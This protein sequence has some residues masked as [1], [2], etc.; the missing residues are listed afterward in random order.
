MDLSTYVDTLRHELA[1]AARSAGPDAE[2]TGRRLTAPLESATRLVL[3]EAVSDAAQEISR[4]LA[5]GSV[6]VRLR[7]RDLGFVVDR[8]PRDRAAPSPLTRPAGRRPRPPHR[9]RPPTAPRTPAPAPA[10]RRVTP[11]PLGSRPACPSPSRRR[12]RR[13]P[14]AKASRST[15][16]SVRTLG[17]ALQPGTATAAPDWHQSGNQAE[18]VGPVTGPQDAPRDP[19]RDTPQDAR[20]G[21]A[22]AAA[23]D[24][25][26][27]VVAPVSLAVSLEFGTVRVHAQDTGTVTARIWPARA[28]R[29]VDIEAAEQSQVHFADNALEIR[30]PGATRRFFGSPGSVDVDVVVPTGSSLRI[31]AGYAEVE[32]TGTV[33]VCAVKTSYGDIRVDDIGRL[34]V[35]SQGGTVT[36]GRVAGPAKVS[37]TYGRIRIREVAAAADLR[38]RPATSPSLGRPATSPRGRPT[39]RSPSASRCAA[40]PRSPGRTARSSSASPPAPPHTSTCGPT[41]ARSAASWTAPPNPVRHRARGDPRANVL[42][43]HHDS[44]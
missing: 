9:L 42:R 36:A 18:R 31:D 26:T 24:T 10:S 5:P 41:T 11:A 3:Q 38:P 22:S 39:A 6:D 15:P 28:T 19:P 8:G 35:D 16:T 32:V 37:S 44:T 4:D 17:A 20:P 25:H 43:R 21:A 23:D 14:S 29:R 30:V 33:D 40:P 2:A 27:F 13:R 7:G 1:V 34:D 12:W